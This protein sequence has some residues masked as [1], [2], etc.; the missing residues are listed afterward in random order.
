MLGIQILS[1]VFVE[2]VLCPFIPGTSPTGDSL[3][4]VPSLDAFLC[5]QDFS[6]M[7]LIKPLFFVSQSICGVVVLETADTGL[8]KVLPIHPTTVGTAFYSA[9]LPWSWDSSL[10]YQNP[11][12]RSP[13]PNF[14]TLSSALPASFQVLSKSA[15]QTSSKWQAP[16][17]PTSQTAPTRS[18]LS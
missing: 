12:K 4:A 14:L 1:S 8:I 16:S 2:K 13:A 15:S 10:N 3:G 5:P 6:A 18:A 9:S 17:G 7:D 11:R